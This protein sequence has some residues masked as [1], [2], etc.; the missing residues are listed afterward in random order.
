MTVC[1]WTG[2]VRAGQLCAAAGLEC[3]L[4]QRLPQPAVLQCLPA[5]TGADMPCMLTPASRQNLRL[6]I[7]VRQACQWSCLRQPRCSMRLCLQ[8]CNRTGGGC[9]CCWIVACMC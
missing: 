5:G 2:E 4:P 6:M 7:K 8:T 1:A 3:S 9:C